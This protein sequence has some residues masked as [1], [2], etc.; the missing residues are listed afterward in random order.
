MWPD[1]DMLLLQYL[2]S[3]PDIRDE[4]ERYFKLKQDPRVLPGIG[5]FLRRTSL[6]ELPQLWNVLKGEMSIVG[7]RPIVAK[8]IERYGEAFTLLKKLKPGITGLWQVSGRND[9]SYGDR[10]RLDSYY[11]KNW[12]I[13]LDL[14]I[15]FRTAG[16]VLFRKGAY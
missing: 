3:S 10:V 7:P 11:V 8:E 12:S 5:R 14:V 6:D 4:W 16:V 13:W 15:L 9:V 2:A 1:A